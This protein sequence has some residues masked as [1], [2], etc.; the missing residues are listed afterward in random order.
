MD[1]ELMKL[2]FAY[3]VVYFYVMAKSSAHCASFIFRPLPRDPRIRLK[4]FG[5]GRLK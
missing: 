3:K 1:I 4:K 5:L 2:L